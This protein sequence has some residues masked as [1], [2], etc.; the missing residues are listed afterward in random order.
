[1]ISYLKYWP[2]VTDLQFHT[3]HIALEAVE[4]FDFSR[5]LQAWSL[6][7]GITLTD[8]MR[9]SVLEKPES[10]WVLYITFSKGGWEHESA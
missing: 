9:C 1:M 5:L 7:E 2:S 8:L 4:A 10:S 6:L 3:G